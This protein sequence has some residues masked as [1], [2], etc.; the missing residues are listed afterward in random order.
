MVHRFVLWARIEPPTCPTPQ[1]L[2]NYP[3]ESM[4]DPP[5]LPIS[6]ELDVDV[7]RFGRIVFSQFRKLRHHSH[8]LSP[9]VECHHVVE[10]KRDLRLPCVRGLSG[11]GYGYRVVYPIR[12]LRVPIL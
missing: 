6:P 10:R 11:T 12:R 4:W 9:G 5:I 1:P 7:G 2:P 8:L 3:H